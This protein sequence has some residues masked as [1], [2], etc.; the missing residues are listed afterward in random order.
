MLSWL[1]RLLRPEVAA[2]DEDE[3]FDGQVP[4]DGVLDLHTFRPRDVAG[5]VRDYVL[6]C[7]EAGVLELRIIHGKG[8]GVQRDVVISVLDA[9]P[10]V[11]ASH[12]IAEP[13]RGGWGARIVDLRSRA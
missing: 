8:K 9:M 12:R 7:Q 2:S 10:G 11:V 6:A 13:A 3:A 1:R 4:L 5:V